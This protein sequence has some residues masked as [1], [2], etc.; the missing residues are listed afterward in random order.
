MKFTDKACPVLLRWREGHLQLLAFRHPLAGCQIVKG[1]VE[2]Y[3]EPSETVVRELGEESGIEDARMIET[4]GQLLLRAEKQRW[5]LF[6]CQVERAL[7]DAWDFYTKDGGGQTFA[8]FWHNLDEI[9]GDEW[10]PAFRKAL[11]F[12]RRRVEERAEGV[13]SVSP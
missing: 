7:P 13:L 1:T 2:E 11:G 3:E 10:H 5:H 12:I 6:L 9:A 8:F 4:W